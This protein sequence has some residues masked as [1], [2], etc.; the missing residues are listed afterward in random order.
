MHGSYRRMIYGI[1]WISGV[2]CSLPMALAAASPGLPV[3]PHM[4]RPSAAIVSR[5]RPPLPAMPY[6]YPRVYIY[7]SLSTSPSADSAAEARPSPEALQGYLR[8]EVTPP[9]T[10]IYVDGH[11]IGRG[12]DFSGPAMVPVSPGGHR[13]EFHA[14][15]LGNQVRVFVSAGETV[16]LSQDLGPVSPETLLPAVKRWV[17]PSRQPAYP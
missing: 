3:A 14:A 17:I 8:L 15:R 5:L 13:V 9:E 11:F 6:P 2:L 4:G 1:A 10:A 16:V 7:G 12:R